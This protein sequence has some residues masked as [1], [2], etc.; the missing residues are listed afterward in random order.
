MHRVPRFFAGLVVLGADPTPAQTGYDREMRAVL[1]GLPL[2][3]TAC[4]HER[5]ITELHRVAGK[6]VTVETYNH[7]DI[8]AVAIRAPD[9]VTFANDAGV[10]P[11][12]SVSRVIERRHGRGA[13]EGAGIGF[14]IG[15]VAGA[16]LGL[17]DGDDE[18]PDTGWC[19]FVFSAEEKAVL[20][21]A[22]FGS[23]GG[24]VGLVVGAVSGSQ[25]VYSY[26]DH[27][28]ITPTGPPGS[29]GGVTIKY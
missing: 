4:T 26:G 3:V 1:V 11:P 23:I 15:A 28:R 16:V 7:E 5:P 25:F 29:V 10:L 20:G 22:T 27:I 13:L 8:Q 12:T 18:C 2:V 21:G 9:G 14:A 17:A 6:R 19:F 24:L